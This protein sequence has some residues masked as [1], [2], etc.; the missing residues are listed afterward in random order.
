[1]NTA[2]ELARLLESTS[3]DQGNGTTIGP[4][5]TSGENKPQQSAEVGEPPRISP[6]L[7][8]PGSA[9]HQLQQQRSVLQSMRVWTVRTVGVIVLLLT[10]RLVRIFLI[11]PLVQQRADTSKKCAGVTWLSAVISSD[12]ES[13]GRTRVN[14]APESVN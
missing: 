13:P 6:R 3:L 12:E 1:M 9:K 5:G 8:G 11:S 7:Q 10:L 4:R 14:G 2:A